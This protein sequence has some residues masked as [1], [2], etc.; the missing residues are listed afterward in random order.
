MQAITWR[1]LAQCA[2]TRR[3]WWS[4]QCRSDGQRYPLLFFPRPQA[5]M[6]LAEYLSRRRS[7]MLLFHRCS[8]VRVAVGIGYFYAGT[9]SCVRGGAGAPG[10][11]PPAAAIVGVTEMRLD[12]RSICCILGTG[13]QSQCKPATQVCTERKSRH[14]YQQS[15]ESVLGAE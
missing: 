15:V 14:V 10:S 6:L 8:F 12:V 5:L 2:N 7:N 1:C 9:Y 13:M 11:R 3:S 4:T